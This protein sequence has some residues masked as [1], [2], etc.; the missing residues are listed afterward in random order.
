M[1]DSQNRL[2]AKTFIAKM[3]IVCR[4]CM[5][6]LWINYV[7]LAMPLLSCDLFRMM[8]TVIMT[9]ILISEAPN[10]WKPVL[11]IFSSDCMQQPC[12]PIIISRNEET[13][14]QRE[15]HG[16]E[17]Q[18]QEDLNQMSIQR[19]CWFQQQSCPMRLCPPFYSSSKSWSSPTVWCGHLPLVR[20]ERPKC[21]A[22]RGTGSASVQWHGEGEE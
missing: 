18:S 10:Y 8:I 6:A 11:N 17:V 7:V 1:I 19:T 13:E 21:E 15:S 14:V 9:M 2:G 20:V 22:W 4:P 5:A 3:Q 12:D 16:S